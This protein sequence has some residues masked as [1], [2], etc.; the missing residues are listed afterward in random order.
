[1]NLYNE[2]DPRA[3]AWLRELITK[4][5][6]PNGVVDERDIQDIRPEEL[7]Q[8]TQCHFFA[9]I[10]GWSHALQLAGWSAD[11]PVWTGSC[12]CTPFSVAGKRRATDDPRHL[13]PAFRWLI[14]QCRPPVIFGEQV[15]SKSG[16][17]WLSGVRADLETLG[18]G[19]GASDLCA[20][21][22]GSP[23]L[24]QRLW[25]M[26][27]TDKPRPQGRDKEVLSE[28]SG[29]LP[30]GPVSASGRLAD[31][32]LIDDDMAGPEPGSD[33]RQ[34]EPEEEV[35]GFSHFAERTWLQCS[36]GKKRRVPSESSLFPLADGIPGR[37]GLLRGAGN[38][39]VPQLAAVFIEAAGK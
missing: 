30:S 11:T 27:N 22:I 32:H 28:C 35:R 19:V 38:A 25:W 34:R 10:G 15:A 1:M 29:Q 17:S 4:K 9:G 23:H 8:Y 6:I 39:I 18:Y 36:D 2:N 7:V 37:V 13:W 3:A 26:A 20:A 31:T 5:L 14:A 24:R 12:P 21:G 16:R 33:S